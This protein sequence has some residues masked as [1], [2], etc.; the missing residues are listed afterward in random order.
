MIE[1]L[2]IL[3]AHIP[4]LRQGRGL[5]TTLLALACFA[6]CGPHKMTVKGIISEI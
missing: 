4:D 2:N 1:S 3:A 6:I 5:I